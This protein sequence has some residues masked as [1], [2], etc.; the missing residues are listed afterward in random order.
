MKKQLSF[1]AVILMMVASKALF[2]QSDKAINALAQSL[3]S[4]KSIE[5]SFTYQTSESETPKE[6]RAYFQDAAYKIIQE[7]QHAISDGKTTWHYIIEN[8]EV[9]V[10]NAT[11]DD[12]P[13]KILDKLER[14]NTG[15]TPVIDPKGNLKKLEIEVDEGVQLIL[16]ISE[17]KFD[18][19]YPDG[20]FS[21]DK[22]A[23]P[24]VE[25]IDMR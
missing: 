10:G 6:G 16:S 3:R 8:E 14:D 2:A 18:Q 11:D 1:F 4:H 17:M 19:V 9:M 13:F 7:D 5:V 22:K 15:I 20:F 21:F 24:N 25:I 23:H 12:N